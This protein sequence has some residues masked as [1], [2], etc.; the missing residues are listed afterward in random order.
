MMGTKIRSF[1]PLPPEISLEDLV[2]EDHF[3]RRLQARLDLSFV[4]E[5]VRPLYAGAAGLLLTLLSSSK[6]SQH[7]TPIEVTPLAVETV[8]VT[9]PTH[10]FHGLELPLVGV[11]RKAGLGAVC[12]V[13]IRRGVERV[14]PVGATDLAE[15]FL[16]VPSPCRLSVDS[17]EA[18]LAV[19]A[20]FWQAPPEEAHAA[21]TGTTHDATHP[22]VRDSPASGPAP[23]D[24]GSHHGSLLPG[25]S[26]EDAGRSGVGSAAQ[27]VD[28]RPEGGRG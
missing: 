11:T 21:E 19:V 7:N 3:Y 1:T 15:E 2:A 28:V 25:G 4:R 24:G 9:D 16:E 8:R 17:A 18:L 26:V 12:V 27:N 13:W 20:S 14:I 10:P 5:L 23:G 22:A 6:P